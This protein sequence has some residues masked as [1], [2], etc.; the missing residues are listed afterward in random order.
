MLLCS[1]QEL[2][3]AVRSR[4]TQIF[5]AVFAGL[6]LAVAASGYILSGGHGVQDFART[7]VS[8]VQLVLLLVPLTALTIGV[9]SLS[10]ER[11]AS[12][13][14]FSQPVSRGTILLGRVLGLFLALAGAQAI[15]FGAAGVVV[16]TRAGEQG[17]GG[18]LLLVLG[19]LVMT[20][21]F[22]GLAALVA[23][24]SAGRRSRPL[25]LALVIWFLAVVLY[26]VAALGV[27]SLLPSG[28]ASRVLILAVVLNPVDAVRTGTLLGI[29][30]T[31][32]FGAASLAFLRFTGGAVNAALLLS[33]SL[34]LWVVLPVAAA[35][36]RLK[37]ADL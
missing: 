16:F 4:W 8:L 3:L 33:I 24:A 7:A 22:L 28:A 35:S 34:A 18:F 23:A 26:D 31:A 25:A 30:G 14:L 15:G 2:L 9:L 37:K 6:S 5:A 36:Y 10:P 20:A 21:V 11:G 19:S 1:Q 17:I 12:E 29:E 13:L 27:A 32:A